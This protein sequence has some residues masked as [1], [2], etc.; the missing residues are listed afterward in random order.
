MSIFALSGIAAPVTGRIL[1]NLRV[2]PLH[3]NPGGQV[4]VIGTDFG[5]KNDDRV[6]TVRL[7]GKV[8]DTN[9]AV[10]KADK[11]NEVNFTLNV[12][13]DASAGDQELTVDCPGGNGATTLHI[14]WTISFTADPNSGRPGGDTDL[15]GK[16]FDCD[17]KPDSATG[18]LDISWDGDVIASGTAKDGAFATTITAPADAVEG[19]HEITARCVSTGESASVRFTVVPAPPSPSTT[20]ATRSPSPSDTTIA[21]SSEPTA[22]PPSPTNAPT[23]RTPARMDP[24]RAHLTASLAAPNDFAPGLL[25]YVILLV[26][27]GAFALMLCLPL[28]A[29]PAEIFN[30]ALEER[31]ERHN[32]PRWPPSVQI[33]IFGALSATLLVLVEPDVAFDRKTL[34]LGVGLMIAVLIT[35][36][37]YCV[38]GELLL[39]QVSRRRSVL[40]TLPVALA[41][42][43]VC[44]IVS[45]VLDF[46][47]GYVYG[48]VAGYAPVARNLGANADDLRRYEG[49]AVLAGVIATLGAS[50]LAWSAWTTITVTPT[51]SFGTQVL[52]STL[53]AI[54]LMGV[55]TVLFGLMPVKLLDGLKLLAWRRRAWAA[56][57]IPTTVAYLVLLMH[58]QKPATPAA[59]IRAMTLFI[60]FGLGSMAFWSY[61]VFRQRHRRGPAKSDRA[62]L[63]RREW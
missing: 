59:L 36:L 49:H 43:C 39:H 18:L 3:Q 6:V 37:S 40:R 38:P 61:V 60:A 19:P 1:S 31:H 63:R 23:V 26:V 51:S 25:L 44:A 52:D 45:R 42:G 24:Q 56:V 14:V 33:T 8:V 17:T 21:P 4:T 34:A 54:A 12:P 15:V 50:V 46:Q 10:P 20:T 11:Q 29:F 9:P 55:E 35:T 47:P 16:R 13:K 7:R 41:I 28:L 53:G 57:Y 27:A 5:C 30:K 62:R 58:D 32:P 48:L 2:D 22:T